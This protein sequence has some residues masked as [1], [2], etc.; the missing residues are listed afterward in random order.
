MASYSYKDWTTNPLDGT[1]SSSEKQS[2]K[3][4]ILG[5][6][7][8]LFSRNRNTNPRGKKTKKKH[9]F[10]FRRSESEPDITDNYNFF[11]KNFGGE[12]IRSSFYESPYDDLSPNSFFSEEGLRKK[13]ELKQKKYGKSPVIPSREKIPESPPDFDIPISAPPS[14]PGLRN[15]FDIS[16]TKDSEIENKD[17]NKSSTPSSR[18]TSSNKSKTPVQ[19]RPILKS[20]PEL[21]PQ[22]LN[23]YEEERH[24]GRPS[25]RKRLSPQSSDLSVKSSTSDR[26][27]RY[28]MIHRQRPFERRGSLPNSLGEYSSGLI[29][30]HMLWHINV[31]KTLNI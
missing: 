25:P 17:D 5:S 31:Y 4:G 13:P 22:H 30:F 2:K 12:G 6:I 8:N 1:L 20:S 18:P 7:R 21:L 16:A 10:P 28:M 11:Q 23:T 19:S 29:Y 24:S 14:R 26:H 15:I 3:P 9:G 27:D